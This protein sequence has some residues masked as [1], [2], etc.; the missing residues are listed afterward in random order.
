MSAIEWQ[1]P[2]FM[3]YAPMGTLLVEVVSKS[4]DYRGYELCRR[5][6]D[7]DDDSELIN[8]DGDSI[9]WRWSDV[10]RYVIVEG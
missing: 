1:R 6:E 4:G 10:K 3:P 9:G 2:M 5:G 8:D 7:L